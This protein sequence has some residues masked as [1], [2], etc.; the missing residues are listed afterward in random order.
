MTPDN[1]FWLTF[2]PMGV[3]VLIGLVGDM[4]GGR[5]ASVARP[6]AAFLL[7]CS[8]LVGVVGGFAFPT[9]IAFREFAVGG[10][11]STVVGAVALISALT[12][13][14][15]PSKTGTAQ[16]VA[17][18]VLGTLGSALAA[19]AVGLVTLALA[20]ETAA[21]CAYAL[22][23]GSRGPRSSE[24]AIK[25]FIQGALAT[26]L[27]LAGVAVLVSIGAPA[28][29]YKEMSVLLASVAPQV[30]VAACAL[31]IAALAFKIGAAPF[32]S[33]APDAYES[34]S[35]NS[36][37]VLAGP[38]KLAVVAALSAFMTTIG[39]S[40]PG[41]GG[42]TATVPFNTTSL[43]LLGAL[44]ICSILVGSLGALSQRG[45]A[46]MLGY[47]G[48][49]QA[50]YALMALASLSVQAVLFFTVSYALATAGAF[51]AAGAFAAEN[52][53]WDGTIAGLAGVGRRDPLLGGAV[54][55]LLISLAGIPP[56]FGF[57]GKL[58]AFTVAVAT[59][60]AWIQL[61]QTPM[62]VIY[63]AMVVV[64]AV[65][66]VIALGYY[67]SVLRSMFFGDAG[68]ASVQLEDGDE[69]QTASA[70][71][72]RAVFIAAILVVALGL[73]PLAVNMTTILR[74]FAVGG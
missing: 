6:A 24:A 43:L 53:E 10:G 69:A 1:L 36:A 66:A 52:P 70:A 13:V 72:R 5:A 26:G 9:A 8:G 11:S 41:A 21:V 31:V 18:V 35:P 67:G 14:G 19:C 45:Y 64:A 17:L 71:P 38:G 74:G 57:W 2:A 42:P 30:S 15:T 60:G 46:R 50:G 4:A 37:A 29:G 22:V 63:S 68:Q 65:G 39:I 51:V 56:L 33:W 28:G 48:V 54:M 62:V 12:I 32:H 58:Q 55:L 27:L 61:G 3:A 59:V 73:V 25:Y 40:I 47:A 49:A 44:S 16:T 34:A 20:L 7:A 23:A